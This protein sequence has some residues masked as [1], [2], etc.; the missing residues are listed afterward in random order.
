MA[1]TITGCILQIFYFM[2][3]TGYIIDTSGNA[4]PW[5]ICLALLADTGAG[6]LAQV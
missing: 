1:K 6:Q 5:S 2:D 3:F 4:V